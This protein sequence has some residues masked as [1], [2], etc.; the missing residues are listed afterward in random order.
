MK[1]ADID[2]GRRGG[3]NTDERAELVALRRELRT[4]KMEVEILRRAAAY[5][6]KDVAWPKMTYIFIARACS[7]LPVAACC[8]VMRV[9][10]SGFYAWRANPVRPED[11]EDACLSNTSSTSG[12]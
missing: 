4:A 6:A 11:L 7:D 9:S 1:Q 2:G 10:T 3:V 12:P 8:R 5:F